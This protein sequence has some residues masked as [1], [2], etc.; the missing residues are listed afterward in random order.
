MAVSMDST[1]HF[2]RH[3]Q[4]VCGKPLELVGS[5]VGPIL[6]VGSSIHSECIAYGTTESVGIMGK[7]FGTFYNKPKITSYAGVDE[8]FASYDTPTM[9]RPVKPF[10]PTE[11]AALCS[12]VAF[13]DHAVCEL[14]TFF[15]CKY[16]R[17]WNLLKV[18]HVF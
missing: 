8:A 5:T 3:D 9:C 10:R 18:V 7:W 13:F 16:L 17:S 4:E 11:P 6:D 2:W 15:M 1:L 14:V 12:L